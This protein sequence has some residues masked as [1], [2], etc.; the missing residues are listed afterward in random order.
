MRNIAFR[1]DNMNSSSLARLSYTV[2]EA[3]AAIGIGRTTLYRLIG[4]G[5]LPVVKIGKRTLIRAADLNRLL[6]GEEKQAA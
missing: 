3:A 4:S 1:T 6:A 5:A 2:D